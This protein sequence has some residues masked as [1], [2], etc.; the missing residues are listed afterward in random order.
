MSA[1]TKHADDQYKIIQAFRTALKD[2]NINTNDVTLL[3]FAHEINSDLQRILAL[4]YDKNA[5]LKKYYSV[6][7]LTKG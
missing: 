1:L 7:E 4:H 6:R 5:L 3:E 2:V